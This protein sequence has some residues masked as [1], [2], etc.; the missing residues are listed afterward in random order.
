MPGSVGSGVFNP[1]RRLGIIHVMAVYDPVRL[2]DFAAD[3]MNLAGNIS[4]DMTSPAEWQVW[5]RSP[6]IVFKVVNF[7]GSDRRS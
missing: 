6:L 4:S 3:N 1:A 7:D 2:E 5:T